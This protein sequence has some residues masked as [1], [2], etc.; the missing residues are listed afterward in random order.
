MAKVGLL[1]AMI[2]RIKPQTKKKEIKPMNPL[3]TSY[4]PATP[5]PSEG[6]SL[7]TNIRLRSGFI[8]IAFALGCFALCPKAQ[9]VSP[10]PDGCYPN[11]TTAEGCNALNFLTS[12]AGNTGMGWYSLYVNTTGSFNTGVGGGALALNNGDS[13]T[14]VGAAALL[15]NTTGTENTAVGTDALVFNDSGSD[16][17]AF[18]TFAL[19]NSTTGSF[20]TATGSRV[21]MANT[22]G[23][24]NTA[25]GAFAL[26][27]NTDGSFNTAIGAFALANN[28]G[29]ENTAVG[30][31]V[32][33]NNSAGGNTGIGTHAL[34][35]N[36]TGFQNTAVGHN[37]L[38]SNTSSNF[39][40]A[41]GSAALAVNTGE[42]N[43]ACGNVALFNNTG[44]NNTALGNVAGTNLT[45]G[46]NNID[47][48]Y[49]VGG[50]AGESNTIRIGNSDITNTFISGISGTNSP[51]GV[52]VFCNSDGKLGVISSSAR[53]KEDIRPMGK[54]SEAILALKPVS[55][56]YKKEIDPQGIPEFGLIAE[57]VE[58]V[59]PDL[60]V[61]D[62]EGKPQTV[63]YEQVNAMLLNEFLKAHRKMEEQQEQIDA[64]TVQLKEQ[65][66]QIQKVSARIE[67]SRPAPHVV[68]NQR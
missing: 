25:N 8:L 53:F 15:L 32:L 24:E 39:N 55:F 44:S 61:R 48:G 62:R 2:N 20:N 29:S 16:N 23:T 68:T 57:E 34:R 19:S 5:K 64:L 41:I 36:T 66:A 46:N 35:L 37:A 17:S 3:I 10:A 63:R 13:N 65:A 9:A 49:N 7:I 11:Y 60:I 18:G 31:D 40:T 38:D 28:T 47:I 56:R 67:T 1:W 30:V 50:V 52:A 6:G 27:A 33:F 43:T 45:I 4:Y 51:G 21:L 54:A 22:T 58:Q 14:P 42:G 12:G 26:S 59:N